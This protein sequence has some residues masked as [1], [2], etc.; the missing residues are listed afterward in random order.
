MYHEEEPFQAVMAN[1]M[2]VLREETDSNDDSEKSSSE[3][4]ANELELPPADDQARQN[5]ITFVR[6]HSMG[7][8]TLQDECTLDGLCNQLEKRSLTE[9]TATEEFLSEALRAV[10]LQK[11]KV[12]KNQLE[13]EL[14]LKLCV[15]CQLSQKTILLLPCRHLCLCAGCSLRPELKNCPLCRQLVEDKFKVFA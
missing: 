12:E 10:T 1:A 13:A 9:L 5:E 15:V 14:E 11:K 3:D 2:S 8:E 7:A 4:E 6:Q